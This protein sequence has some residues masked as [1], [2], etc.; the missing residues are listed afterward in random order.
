M[1]ML[2]NITSATVVRQ[3]FGHDEDKIRQNEIWET[4]DETLTTFTIIKQL[5]I[6]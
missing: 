6:K 5:G 1:L 3:A 4:K 2:K